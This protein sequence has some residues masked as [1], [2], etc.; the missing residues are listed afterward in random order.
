MIRVEKC[1]IHRHNLAIMTMKLR[2]A[3]SDEL[4]A[5]TGLLDGPGLVDAV[6]QSDMLCYAYFNKDKLIALSG[7]TSTS[8]SYYACVWAM[9]TDDVLQHWDEI[10]PL[11]IRHVNSVLDMPGITVIGNAIDLRN[12]A[13]IRW[14]KKLGFIMTGDTTMLG[15]VEFEAFYKQGE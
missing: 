8:W 7:A 10:E 14:I 3:D 9:G 4:W 5:S 15:G 13:H 6:N 11:F 12:T 2:E 1:D